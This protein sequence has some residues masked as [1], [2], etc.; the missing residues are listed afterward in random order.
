MAR[1]E[2]WLTASN[3]LKISI[4]TAMVQPRSFCSLKPAA[5]VSESNRRAD[6]VEYGGLKLCFGGTER[7]GEPFEDLYSWTEA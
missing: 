1:S 6:M 3:A 5:M 4:A 7:Q 2:L